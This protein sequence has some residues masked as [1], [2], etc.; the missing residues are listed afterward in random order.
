MVNGTVSTDWSRNDFQILVTVGDYIFK[1]LLSYFYT[2]DQTEMV[3]CM[4][5]QGLLIWPTCIQNREKMQQVLKCLYFYVKLNWATRE[6]CYIFCIPILQFFGIFMQQPFCC[7][8]LYFLRFDQSFNFV[9]ML[10]KIAD[11]SMWS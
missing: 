8:C 6:A 1:A 5:C 2:W 3:F 7:W 10:R 11:V 4:Q 9:L